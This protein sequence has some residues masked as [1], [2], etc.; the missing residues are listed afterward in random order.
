[1]SLGI[2]TLACAL[3]TEVIANPGKNFGYAGIR[4]ILANKEN[5]RGKEK[6]VTIRNDKKNYLVP[7]QKKVQKNTPK[8]FTLVK[9]GSLWS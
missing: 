3:G 1:M 6:E 7:A 8:T 5:G 2:H 9:Q 4:E